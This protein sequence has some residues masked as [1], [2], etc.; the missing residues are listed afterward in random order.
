MNPYSINDRAMYLSLI[1]DADQEIAGLRAGMEQ[2]REQALASATL[3][4]HHRY[5]AARMDLADAIRM[6]RDFETCLRDLV[7]GGEA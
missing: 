5:I 3:A 4:S 1:A 7:P 6:R 2:R